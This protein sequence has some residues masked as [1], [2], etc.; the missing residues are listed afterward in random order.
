MYMR[1]Y[2]RTDGRT[3]YD[4]RPNDNE[5]RPKKFDLWTTT[6]ELRA[7]RTANYTKCELDELMNKQ[8]TNYSLRNAFLT[9]FSTENVMLSTSTLHN[10]MLRQPQL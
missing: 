6:Y 4:N 8:T 5:F 2:G 1:T 10:L 9:I 3:F 7:A